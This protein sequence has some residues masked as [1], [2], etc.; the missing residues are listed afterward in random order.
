[1]R[2]AGYDGTGCPQRVYRLAVEDEGED[3]FWVYLK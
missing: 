1:M 3:F 2:G